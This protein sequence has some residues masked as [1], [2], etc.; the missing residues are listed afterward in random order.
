MV[1][2]RAL[3]R[4]RLRAANLALIQIHA[5]RK[6]NTRL[7]RHFQGK[8]TVVHTSTPQAKEAA[9]ARPGAS[10][11]PGRARPGAARDG[12]FPLVCTPAPIPIAK[13]GVETPQEFLM[14]CWYS[15]YHNNRYIFGQGDM[16]CL[17]SSKR[18]VEPS[19]TKYPLGKYPNNLM[20][21]KIIPRYGIGAAYRGYGDI[22]IHLVFPGILLSI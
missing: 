17:R 21:Y 12:L 14:P 15:Y 22:M 10:R 13:S 3:G 11:V 7:I 18:A 19:R 9:A 8:R 16:T 5:V 1:I 2:V 20:P 6:Y 4:C